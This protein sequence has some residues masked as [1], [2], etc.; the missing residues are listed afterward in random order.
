M[1]AQEDPSSSAA[2]DLNLAVKLAKI[3]QNDLFAAQ[4][5]LRKVKAKFDK[6]GVR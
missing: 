5:D 6:R 1:D 4:H 2:S 3:N